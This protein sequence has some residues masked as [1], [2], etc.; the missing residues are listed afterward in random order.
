MPGKKKGKK[1]GGGKKKS[2]KGSKKSTK[3]SSKSTI[4]RNEEVKTD[5]RP[6]LLRPGEKLIDLLT[7]HPV[8]EKEVH[9]I[10][11]STRVLEQLTPQEIR[12]LKIVFDIFDTNS[13][14]YIGPL[15][16]RKALRTLG[17]KVSKQEA[18]QISSDVKV[19][20]KK[21]EINFNEFL[22]IVIDRQGDTRDIYD[23]IQKGFEM[24]DFDNT[25]TISIEKL[26]R[27]CTLSGIKFT[28]KELEDM[29]EEAD[30]N[31]DGN[32]DQSEFIQIM[33]QTNLF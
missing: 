15:D 31:G 12:D 2:K 6:P 11:V 28:Q 19:K 3:S 18:I 20:G 21:T 27:A 7:S 23:E 4:S 16:L 1:G 8:E 24:L 13:D 33:L 26:K 9:G 30:V 22:E 17:F 5:S 29:M 25:G 14:G 32:V 10:K